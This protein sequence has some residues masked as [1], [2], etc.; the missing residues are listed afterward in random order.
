MVGVIQGWDVLAH[1]IVTIQCFGWRVFFRAVAPWQAN[2]FLSLLSS[3]GFSR[4]NIS[5]VP[6]ILDRCINLELRAK[7]VYTALSKALEDEELVG[8]FFSGLAEQ[9]QHH[10]DLL[11]ICRVAAARHRWRANL[12][13]PWQD[14]LPRL[15]I[16][17]DTTE[18]AL[19]EINSTDAALRLVVER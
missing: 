12:F 11:E 9:E 2:T 1:P 13:N 16:Q 19:R 7:R 14:Y 17:M 5:S 8:I 15:E 18:L 3:S 10:A 6:T 4:P